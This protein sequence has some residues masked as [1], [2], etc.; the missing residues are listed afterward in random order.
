MASRV[1]GKGLAESTMA[2]LTT[3]VNASGTGPPSNG[4]VAKKATI[5]RLAESLIE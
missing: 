4:S 3:R 2:L 5:K 1:I